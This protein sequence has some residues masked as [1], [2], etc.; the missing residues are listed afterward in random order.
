M[1]LKLKSLLL[2]LTIFL[3]GCGS[4]TVVTPPLAKPAP[5]VIPLSMKVTHE[6]WFCLGKV[7]ENVGKEKL[8]RAKC[9][10]YIKLGQRDNL[11]S[12]RIDTLNGV[13]DSTHKTAN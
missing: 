4:I 11:K 9:K 8:R 2:A 12:A 1:K 3:N 6:E 13:I 5:L 7:H 10:A